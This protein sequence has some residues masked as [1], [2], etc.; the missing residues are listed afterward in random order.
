MPEFND[1]AR[2]HLFASDEAVRRTYANGRT[3]EALADADRSSFR[4]VAWRLSELVPRGAHG[5]PGWGIRHPPVIVVGRMDRRGAIGIERQGFGLRSVG[6]HLHIFVKR[7]LLLDLAAQRRGKPGG[8][9]GLHLDRDWPFWEEPEWQRRHGGALFRWL[10][11]PVDLPDGPVPSEHP[12]ADEHPVAM[13]LGEINKLLPQSE[14][15]KPPTIAELLAPA[16]QAAAAPAG[17][18]AIYPR[19][20]ALFKEGQAPV[21]RRAA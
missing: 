13:L 16:R 2:Q 4:R 20:I 9:A 6:G 14:D 5:S 19:L 10:R 1:A 8:A 3:V 7:K 15:P 12:L 11:I 17:V 18:A 21:A